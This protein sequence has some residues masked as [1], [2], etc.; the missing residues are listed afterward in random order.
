MPILETLLVSALE[1]FLADLRDATAEVSA[2]RPSLVNQEAN[3]RR[4]TLGG[5]VFPAT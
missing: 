3:R 4:R 5:V 1:R 2:I